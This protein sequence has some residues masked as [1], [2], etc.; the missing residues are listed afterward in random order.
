MKRLLRLTRQ[1]RYLLFQALVITCVMRLALSFLPLQKVQRLGKRISALTEGSAG[2]DEIVG[3][4]HRAARLIP[5]SNCLL[6]ALAAQMLLIRHGYRPRLTIGVQKT[7]P[8]GFNAHAWITCSGEILMGG[9][10]AQNYSS[11]LNLES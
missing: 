6:Q 2:A 10:H 3:A 4:V 8:D 1:Q 7:K 11:L 9:Q 5:G